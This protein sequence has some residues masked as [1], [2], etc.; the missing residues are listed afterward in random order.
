[1]IKGTITLFSSTEDEHKG[2]KVQW[3]IF[4]RIQGDRSLFRE[5]Y[6]NV[7]AHT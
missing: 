6:E 1:M 3:V 4:N 7:I 2:K 5:L